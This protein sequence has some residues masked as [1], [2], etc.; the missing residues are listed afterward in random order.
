MLYVYIV[1]LT[2]IMYTILHEERSEI[3]ISSWIYVISS[4]FIFLSL[5]CISEVF[6]LIQILIW[7][8]KSQILI[9]TLATAVYRHYGAGPK[10][11]HDCKTIGNATH[12][13]LVSHRSLFRDDFQL[14]KPNV[15]TQHHNPYSFF[16]YR[17]NSWLLGVYA[18]HSQFSLWS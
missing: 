15:F 1:C 8:A 14:Y 2:Q 10:H 6:Y 5:L 12:I 3:R 11:P 16:L 18:R 4:G 17:Q 9:N 7:I 13:L